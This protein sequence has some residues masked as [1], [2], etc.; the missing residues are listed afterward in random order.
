[1]NILISP[2]TLLIKTNYYEYLRQIIN[3]CVRWT[4]PMITNKEYSSVII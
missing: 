3:T 2:G 4:Q 1:M